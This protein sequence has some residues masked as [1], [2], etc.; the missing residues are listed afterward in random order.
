MRPDTYFCELAIYRVAQSRFNR[1]YDRALAAFI[2]GH[3]ATHKSLGPEF[4]T[5]RRLH[6]E[7]LFWREYG[8]P[9]HYNQAIGWLRLFVCGSQLRGDLWFSRLKRFPR[10]MA[11][12]QLSLQGKAFELWLPPESSSSQ[13]AAALRE[14]LLRF[15]SEFRGGKCVLDL[16]CF[17]GISPFVDWVRL[18]KGAA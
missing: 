11:R 15:Q 3:E 6:L 9:W 18:M 8:A 1:E 10:R 13:I 5:E 14:E 17:D 4:T 16:E 2:G 7:D 12:H